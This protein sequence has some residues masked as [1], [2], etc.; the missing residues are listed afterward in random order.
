MHTIAEKIYERIAQ[1]GTGQLDDRAVSLL[2]NEDKIPQYNL[3]QIIFWLHYGMKNLFL[4]D[5]DSMVM[6]PKDLVEILR[7][8]RERFPSIERIT[9]YSRS[10][11]L[12]ARTP[13][14]LKEIR[15]AGLNRIHIG[16]ESGSDE[17]LKLIKKGVTGDEHISSGRKVVEAG[18]ELSEYYMPGIG[19]KTLTDQNAEETAKVLNAVNPSFIRIRTTTPVQGTELRKMMDDGDWIPLSEK[20][21]V[22]EIRYMISLLE[23]ISSY[24]QS[25]HMMNL[26][27]DANGKLP[28]DKDS[29]LKPF[30][31]FLNMSQEDQECFIIG[32]RTGQ[33]RF[34]ADYKRSSQLESLR[35]RMINSYGNIDNAAMEL[36][37]RFI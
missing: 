32:R 26:I 9:C 13:D 21:R 23:G 17:V 3:Q 16:M 30:D 1:S 36:S 27:E 22:E 33:I 28:G 34:L 24:V 18:F 12:V 29:I 14:E 37:G 10:K 7:Y 11:T 8:I 4:Q 31:T 15:G 35:E 19:G 5:A 2:I 6:K 25:D 20:G